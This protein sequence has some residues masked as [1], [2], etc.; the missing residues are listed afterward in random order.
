MQHHVFPKPARLHAK[1]AQRNQRGLHI[2]R[3]LEPVPIFEQRLQ[4]RQQLQG[5]N[6]RLPGLPRQANR[7]TYRHR[8]WRIRRNLR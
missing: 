7:R 2:V 5:N 8:H 4:G 3:D 1:P 6:S